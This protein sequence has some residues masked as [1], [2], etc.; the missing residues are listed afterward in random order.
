[1]HNDSSSLI[2]V[3]VDLSILYKAT[4]LALTQRWLPS[5]LDP[6]KADQE[7]FRQSKLLKGLMRYGP[8][9]VSADGRRTLSGMEHY[10]ERVVK[11]P[12]YYCSVADRVIFQQQASRL[13][14]YM[15]SE[16][17]PRA[18]LVVPC[19]GK[20]EKLAAF[21][22]ANGYRSA[23]PFIILNDVFTDNAL[24]SHANVK[25]AV[26]PAREIR[27]A[28]PYISEV[29]KITADILDEAFWRDVI[30]K[31]D[32]LGTDRTVILIDAGTFND[33]STDQMRQLLLSFKT[34][35]H[36]LVLLGIDNTT[37]ESALRAAYDNYALKQFALTG[38]E[39]HLCAPSLD[40]PRK[41]RKTPADQKMPF[42]ASNA[43]CFV[44][45]VQDGKAAEVRMSVR[46]GKVVY[47]YNAIRKMPEED[48][49]QL[50]RE[51]GLKLL[52]SQARM[53][54][55]DPRFPKSNYAIYAL[56]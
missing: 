37:D 4:S 31:V 21:F 36:P 5:D 1:M 22:R 8:L 29:S 7:F 52:G 19:S 41:K 47:R 27:S 16:D 38:L 20:G 28:F 6:L 53:Q 45:I 50:F 23:P 55:I 48:F 18:T 26:T 49:M 11:M 35:P 30:K 32:R 3:P 40:D 33:F 9:P 56:S 54:F 44:D 10:D 24:E 46:E 15:I 42:D 34:L 43:Q 25:A 2:E 39:H 17:L 12:D 14:S 13:V 51:A